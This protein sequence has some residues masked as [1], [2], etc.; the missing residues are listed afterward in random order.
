MDEAEVD[1]D[2]AM[3]ADDNIPEQR[4]WRAAWAAE[5]QDDAWTREIT[6]QVRTRAES[7]LDGEV[8]LSD[9]SCRETICRMYL[10]FGDQLDAKAF[11]DAPHDP[12]L[13]YEYQS[14]DPEFDGAGFD[15]SDYTYEVLIKRSRPVHLAEREPE[16]TPSTGTVSRSA[17]GTTLRSSSERN[18]GSV[19]GGAEVVTTFGPRRR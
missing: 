13:H 8:R 7:L 3:R 4:A 5:H 2:E 11:I 9:L 12:A 1:E 15:R 19:R 17:I 18:E 6:E 16:Q 10:Q 14:L